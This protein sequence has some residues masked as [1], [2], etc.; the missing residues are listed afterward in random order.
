MGQFGET[1]DSVTRNVLNVVLPDGEQPGEEHPWS[2]LA[3]RARARGLQATAGELRGMP[4]EVVLTD[5]VTRWL[6]T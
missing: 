4:Y 5:A 6:R 1:R 2:W 3:D